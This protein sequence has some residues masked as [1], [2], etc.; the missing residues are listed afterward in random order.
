M[1]IRDRIVDLRRVPAADLV[2]NPKNW[3]THPKRQ[4]DALRG[5][6][7]DVG[8]ADALLAR[9]TPTGLMLIDGHLRAETLGSQP[10]PVLVLDVTEEEADK[11]L[12]TLD[13]L[14]AMAGTD[15]DAL[16]ALLT[17]L[18]T[19]DEGVEM[20]FSELSRTN[21]LNVAETPQSPMDEWVGMPEYENEKKLEY[22]QIILHFADEDAVE[23][24]ASL[25]G[26]KI[27]PQTR[28]LWHPPQVA[29]AV[30]GKVEWV[31]ES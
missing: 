21:H 12:A 30:R 27:T 1:N 5:L 8:I 20:L 9:E 3:R 15:S 28:Y 29:D 4:Q 17:T 24:F 13:P 11:L 18:Q 23:S 2:P 16:N 22:Q 31:H 19:D 26:Q 14:A 7:A 6:L 10:V 25:I